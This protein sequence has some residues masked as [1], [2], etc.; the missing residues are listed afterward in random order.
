MILP[1]CGSRV[2]GSHRL[3]LKPWTRF[4]R[5]FNYLFLLLEIMLLSKIIKIHLFFWAFIH[6]FYLIPHLPTHPSVLFPFLYYFYFYS[7]IS[8]YSHKGNKTFVPAPFH[9]RG[10]WVWPTQG[11]VTLA[12]PLTPTSA[13]TEPECAR[14]Q[15]WTQPQGSGWLVATAD[16]GAQ[17]QWEGSSH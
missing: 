1:V 6:P 8:Y 3:S 12:L 9:R 17:G 13:L 11:H 14:C 7:I 2:T 15:R 16:A 10:N 4:H 5:T